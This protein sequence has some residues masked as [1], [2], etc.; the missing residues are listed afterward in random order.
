MK[1]N[2]TKRRERNKT[3]EKTSDAQ[4]SCSPPADRC[5]SSNPPLP[6]NSPLVYILSMTFYGMEYPFG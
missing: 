4:C 2:I 5:L 6:A 1:R 3:Q